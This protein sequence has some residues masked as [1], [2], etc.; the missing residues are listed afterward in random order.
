MMRRS[1]F[2]V[3]TPVGHRHLV[4]W[5]VLPTPSCEKNLV[6][7]VSLISCLCFAASLVNAQSE[8]DVQLAERRAQERLSFQSGDPWSPRINLNADVAMVYGIGSKLP[9]LVDSWR[10]NGYRVEL[11]TGVAWGGYQDY[12]DGKFDGT[13]HWDQAQTDSAGKPIIHGGNP[14]VPYMSPGENYGR[15]LAEG[16]K[17]ALDLGVEAVYLEEPEFWA[18]SGWEENF[19]REWKSYYHEDWRA[20]DSSPDAQYR[21]SKL[22]YYLYRRALGQVFDIV[23]GYGKANGRA[24]PCYVATHSLINY[25]NW[26]IVSPESSLIDVGADGYIA[27]VWTG[28][29]RVPNVYDGEQKE[30]TFETAFLEYGA[31]ENLARASRRR[32][33][34]L[35]DPIEDNPNHTWEDYR[36]NW[37]STLTASLLEPEVWRYEVMPWPTRV[38]TGLHPGKALDAQKYAPELNRTPTGAERSGPARKPDVP[39]VRIPQAYE[40]ELQTVISALGD[41]KQADVRWEVAGTRNVGVLVSDTMMFERAAPQASDPYLGSFYALAMPLVKRGIPVEPV[42]I[43]SAMRPGF[44]DRYKLLLLT[45]EGQKPPNEEFH[46]A[47]AKWVRDGGALLVVDNDDDPYNAVR[48]WWD[49]APNN[50]KAP[51]EHLFSRL[52]IPEDGSGLFHAGRGVV[53]SE[54]VSPAALTYQKDGGETLR[55]FA[56]QAAAAVRLPWRETNGLVL[57]RGPYVIAA[58]LDESIPQA[59]PVT[60]HG[61]FINLFDADLPVLTDMKVGPGTRGLLYDLGVGGGPSPRVVAA[62]CRIRGEQFNGHELS[63]S[64]DGL[65]DTSA[66]VRIETRRK[67]VSVAIGGQKLNPGQYKMDADALLVR[68]R[69]SIDPVPISIEF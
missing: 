43:E 54:R 18:R 47:L 10:R 33:W 35:N 42:Q 53:L 6:K 52:G 61:R 15:Y 14:M 50:F 22:K 12:L 34:Y 38:F 25:A 56:R 48:E 55:K 66:V 29:A 64:A 20:P 11:M 32:V 39:M 58:G 24:I 59:K 57:R 27:Q 19:K 49:T 69:N 67:P 36:A 1:S 30:R 2:E 40:T 46:S 5:R 31:I 9:G 21:A 16:V 63:F 26:R 44:L 68:F 62:A 60:L 45:Y 51:R 37:Q 3:C 8:T 13:S 28:T 65:A 4:D 41:M 7:F 17:R 23:S